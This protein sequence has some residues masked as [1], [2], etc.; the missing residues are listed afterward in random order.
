MNS[1][2]IADLIS[3]LNARIANGETFDI[4]TT[5]VSKALAMVENPVVHSDADVL[6]YLSALNLLNAA[7]KKAEYK[8]QLS[9]GIIKTRAAALLAKIDAIKGSSISYYYNPNEH[10]LYYKYGEVVFSFHN[11][12]LIPEML[13]ASRSTP[14]KWGGIRLQQIAQPLFMACV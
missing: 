7:I 6:A 2:C 1:K 12:P 8:Q 13:K 11:V 3:E 5:S 4:D 9:Y 14:I 10:C